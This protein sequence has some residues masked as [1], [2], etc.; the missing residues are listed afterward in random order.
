[1]T[2]VTG[3]VENVALGH[4]ARQRWNPEDRWV[5]SDQPAHPQIITEE[6]FKDF[7]F[8]NPLRLHAGMNPKFF[9]GTICEGAVAKALK[10]GID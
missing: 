1:M 4:A 3:V 7:T 10:E 5:C 2:N 8:T 6:D 9:E